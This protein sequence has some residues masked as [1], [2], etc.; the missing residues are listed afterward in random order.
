MSSETPDAPFDLDVV[1]VGGGGHVGLPL[2]VSFA[3]TGARV[4]L[5]DING[6]VVDLINGGQMP[7]HER[8]APEVLRR[9][10][11]AGTLVATTDQEV[12]ARAENV[13]VVIGT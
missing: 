11:D 8:G 2:G 3:D 7:F 12:I 9:V 6:P 13:V 5:Y 4:A 10:R 1:V